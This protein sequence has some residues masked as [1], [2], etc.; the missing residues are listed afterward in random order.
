M[1][2]AP[3]LPAVE[4][5]GTINGKIAANAEVMDFRLATDAWATVLNYAINAPV[6]VVYI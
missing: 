5:R 4:Q 1:R 6:Q 2:N 3:V